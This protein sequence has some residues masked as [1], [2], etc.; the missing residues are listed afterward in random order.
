MGRILA[1]A[2][3]MLLAS[4]AS[5]QQL[6]DLFDVSNRQGRDFAGAVIRLDIRDSVNVNQ[7]QVRRCDTDVQLPFYA[8]P[9]TV[10][11]DSLVLWVR[12]DTLKRSSTVTIKVLRDAAQ[13]VSRSSGPNTF[14]VF[15]ERITPTNATSPAGPFTTWSGAPPPFG[16]GMIIEASMRA[17]RAG[18]G[19][20]A[21]FGQDDTCGNAYVVQHDARTSSSDP[22]LYRLSNGTPSNLGTDQKTWGVNDTVRYTIR[23]KSDSVFVTRFSVSNSSNPHV[24]RA[25]R[26]EVGNA[27][28]TFGVANLPSAAGS[29]AVDW[30]RARPLIDPEPVVTRKPIDIVRSPGSAVV[31]GDLPVILTAPS[32]WTSYQWSDGTAGRNTTA[33]QAGLYT[34]TV[35][36][37][38]GCAVT[39]PGIQV[40]YEDRPV[41]GND[42][43][44]NLCFGRREILRVRPGMASYTWFISTGQKQTRLASTLDTVSIDSAD[45]YTCIAASALGCTDTVL[46]RVNRVFDNTAKINGA[47]QEFVICDGDSVVL[48]AQPPLSS[49]RW[50]RDSIQLPQTSQKI[51]VRDSGNYTVRVRVGGDTN[52]CISIA[53]V[54]VVFAKPIPLDIDTNVR[55]CEGDSAVFVI[56]NGFTRVEWSNGARTN[57][58]VVRENTTLQLVASIAGACAARRR[59]TVTV[60][61]SP[62]IGVKSVDGRTS[63][64]RGESLDLEFVNDGPSYTWTRNDTVVGSSKRLTVTVPGSYVGLVVYPN[65]CV[66]SDT[67]VIDDGLA[68]PELVAIDGQAICAGDSTR[69]T[70]AGKFQTY[71]WSTGETD[72]TIWI[73]EPGT[74]S[75]R[76]TLFECSANSSILIEPADPRGPAI[77]I[78]DT[79]SLCPNE[80]DMFVGITNAQNV[81]RDYML[82]P[83]SSDFVVPEPSVTIPANTTARI[84]V[85]LASGGAARMLSCPLIVKDDCRWIDTISA[86]VDYGPKDVPVTMTLSTGNAQVRSGD[87]LSFSLIGSDVAGLRRFRWNDTVWLT[88]RVDPDLVQIRSAEATCYVSN[89][90]VNDAEGLVTYVLSDCAD[91]T[92]APFLQ[93]ELTVLTGTT[94]TTAISIDS[95]RGSNP[96]FVL[97]TPSNILDV[98]IAPYGCEL[99]TIQRPLSPVISVRNGG[100]DNVFVDVGTSDVDINVFAVDMLGRVLSSH[101]VRVSEGDRT[102]PIELADGTWTYIHAVSVHGSMT[103]PVAGGR[104]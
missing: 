6:V 99:S 8:E 94:L 61:P 36:D 26:T 83:L 84:A 87:N 77:S 46:F 76:V 34:V 42:T 68:A 13:S 19:L 75:V 18:G 44:F 11:T 39:L 100:V 2:A 5:A 49:Y 66:K 48:E 89:V 38:N 85:R 74:Y 95:V 80:P 103:V 17:T 79:V 3:M 24:L 92:V 7:L 37:N 25:K 30:V 72:D 22:D 41:V 43:A 32:G 55:I 86:V 73:K 12:I 51:I 88:V 67:I 1:V 81:P 59:I 98:P 97:P 65:G 54:R 23:L 50:F 14:S 70:T 63:I 9:W 96:C 56:P 10:G 102:V 62:K 45:F 31:C 20:F 21:F 27:W 71:L 90:V 40:Q 57:R 82:E 60:L 58:L 93:Q 69:L 29:F 16:S 78:G 35:R 28:V 101:V 91:G 15:Q 33:R 47:N 53:K 4:V 104:Q 52:A 64:C